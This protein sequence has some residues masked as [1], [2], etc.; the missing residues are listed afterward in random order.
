[1]SRPPISML[2][3]LASFRPAIL[4]S[5]VDLPQP[6]G[7]SS[8]MNS[9]APTSRSSDSI[10]LLAPSWICRLRME[11]FDMTV[12][13]Y[14]LTLDGARCDAAYEPAAGQEVQCQRHQ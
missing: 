4:C 7:P 11:T 13:L 8:T 6:E 3:P 5:S 1:M 9:P 12:Y 14:P 2:P 10:T